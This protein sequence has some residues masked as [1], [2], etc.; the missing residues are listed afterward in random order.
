MRYTHLIPGLTYKHATN[1]STYRCKR[2]DMNGK[3]YDAKLERE[4]DR[5]TFIAHGTRMDKDGTICWDYSTGGHWE[6]EA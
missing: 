2:I 5:W 4:T 3:Y 6:N 1:G